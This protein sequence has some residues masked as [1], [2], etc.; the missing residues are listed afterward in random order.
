MAEVAKGYLSEL[1][2]NTAPRPSATTLYKIATALGTSVSELLGKPRQ[3]AESEQPFEIPDSLREYLAQRKE[4]IPEAEIRMLAGIRYRG[5][6]PK[7]P[8]DW[9]YIY[10]SIRLRTEGG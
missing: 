9:H 2:A 3:A 10:E 7:T 8:E 4:P 6:A 5:K 1:E